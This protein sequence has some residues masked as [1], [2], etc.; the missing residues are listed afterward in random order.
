MDC[1]WPSMRPC[2]LGSAAIGLSAVR[3]D[4]P[5]RFFFAVLALFIALLL[6][7]MLFFSRWGFSH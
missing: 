5:S 3:V 7:R 4:R 2:L 1:K 6:V